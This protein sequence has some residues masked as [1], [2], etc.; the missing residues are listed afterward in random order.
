MLSA[1]DDLPHYHREELPMHT[2]TIYASHHARHR[3]AQRNLS[4]ADVRFVL[5]YG[6]RHYCAGALHVFLGRRDI[7]LEREL[8]QRHAHLEG[9]VLILQILG[10]ELLLITAYRNRQALK[11]IRTKQPYDMR[12]RYAQRHHASLDMDVTA[13]AQ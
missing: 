1:T 5:E 2:P 11:A 12:R 10:S 3:T 8:Y 4:D 9:T 6:Q 13:S 7:P